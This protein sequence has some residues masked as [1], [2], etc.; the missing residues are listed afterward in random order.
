MLFFYNIAK[1]WLIISLGCSMYYSS[2]HCCLHWATHVIVK[3]LLSNVLSTY[4]GKRLS[5]IFI[6]KELHQ[7]LQML[8]CCWHPV[9]K[10]ALKGLQLRSDCSFHTC[11][12]ASNPASIS[13]KSGRRGVGQHPPH[14]STPEQCW[15]W[16]S[17]GMIPIR[18]ENKQAPLGTNKA[19]GMAIC[20]F[21]R[22]QSN[23]WPSA[24]QYPQYTRRNDA[25][26][27]FSTPLQTKMI[28]WKKKKRQ[29]KK[30]AQSFTW[31]RGFA[32][33]TPLSAW[34]PWQV[35]LNATR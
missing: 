27:H 17:I 9:S 3:Y 25:H 1:L 34:S 26:C 7:P 22:W 16:T 11:S 2:S 23:L 21:T 14:S 15:T 5:S 20:F 12:M 13:L 19:V 28:E 8:L 18:K 24:C 29:I 33:R 30:K 31:L 32:K 4:K 10:A 35:S 6:K